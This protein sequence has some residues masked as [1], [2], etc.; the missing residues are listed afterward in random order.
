[1][2]KRDNKTQGKFEIENENWNFLRRKKHICATGIKAPLFRIKGFTYCWC[3][4]ALYCPY[5]HG[6]ELSKAKTAI[7]AKGD[8]TFEMAIPIFKWTDGLSLLTNGKSELD[9]EQIE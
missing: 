3:I 1:M 9:K 7:L 8:A 5:C 2:V 6:C 4:P